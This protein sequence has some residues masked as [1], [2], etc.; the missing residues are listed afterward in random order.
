MTEQFNEFFFG[1]FFLQHSNNLL[2]YL[3]YD[4][5]FFAFKLYKSK[6]VFTALWMDLHKLFFFYYCYLFIYAVFIN[7]GWINAVF[8][9]LTGLHCFN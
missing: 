2:A 8:S 4:N 3:I 6:V 7:L 1:L 5:K 9:D